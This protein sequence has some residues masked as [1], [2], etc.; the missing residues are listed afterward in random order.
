MP[1]ADGEGSELGAGGGMVGHRAGV[2]VGLGQGVGRAAADG[3]TWSQAGRLIAGFTVL[4][5]T[6]IATL[7]PYTTLCRSDGVG[8]GDG[9]TQVGPV[10]RS[11]DI[12]VQGA[13]L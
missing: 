4:L 7:F 2:D 6:P 10:G 12:L 11:H 9:V 13:G 3:A 8:V 1:P 5:I